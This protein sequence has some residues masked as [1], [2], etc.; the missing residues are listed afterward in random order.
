[1]VTS[2]S[3]GQ[4]NALAQQRESGAAVHLAFDHLELV[5]GALDDA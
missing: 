5:D 2:P 1:M 3:G 4:E